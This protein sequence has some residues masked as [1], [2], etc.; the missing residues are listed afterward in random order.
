MASKAHEL[1]KSSEVEE[2]RRIIIILFP[3][4]KMDGKKL[5]F[6]LRKKFDMFVDCKEH[7]IW[8]GF[9]DDYRTFLMSNNN[10]FNSIHLALKFP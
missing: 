6:E 4:L 9:V 7:P 3:N 10:L 2:K 8:L 1:F 5:V